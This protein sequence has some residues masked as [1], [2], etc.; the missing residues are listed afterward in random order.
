MG[1]KAGFPS[2][3]IFRPISDFTLGVMKK[4]HVLVIAFHYPP[5]TTVAIYR[6]LGF[7]KHFKKYNL[8][9]TVITTKDGNLS[10][11]LAESKPY[12]EI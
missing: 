4:K 8:E 11:E 12:P 5:K 7:L 6:T 1:I 10:I 9:A 3:L 2:H